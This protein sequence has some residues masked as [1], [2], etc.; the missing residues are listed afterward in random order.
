MRKPVAGVPVQTASTESKLT[1]VGCVASV[2][3]MFTYSTAL[4]VVYV[5][6][7][8]F[9]IW[10]SGAL[11]ALVLH[12][13]FG[14]VGSTVADDN[15]VAAP[16]TVTLYGVAA[17]S[18]TGAFGSLIGIAFAQLSLAGT[19]AHAAPAQPASAIRNRAR[20]ARPAAC[21]FIVPLE[22]VGRSWSWV[23]SG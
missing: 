21:R 4:P 11:K 23:P 20:T 13:I 5:Y 2:A 8:V 16:P 9:A 14:S 12:V 6:Q 10:P 7:R 3:L 18:A 17:V 15:G 22:F 1:G 19:C